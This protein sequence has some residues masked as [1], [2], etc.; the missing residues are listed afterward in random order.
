MT[1]IFVHYHLRGGGV[2]QVLKEQCRA[3]DQLGWDHGVISSQPADFCARNVVIDALDYQ[4]PHASQLNLTSCLNTVREWPL[5]RIWHIHNP[6]LG[7]HPQMASFVQDLLHHGERVILHI[8]DLAEDRRPQ[9]LARLQRHGQPW[10]LLSPRVHYLVL[11]QRDRTLLCRAGLPESQATVLINPITPDPLPHSA[12]VTPYVLYP[13]RAITRKNIGELLLLSMLAPPLSRFAT[14]QG[15]GTSYHQEEYSYWR[16]LA[17][18]EQCPIDWEVTENPQCLMDFRTLKTKATHL[19]STSTQEGFG[20]IFL[21]AIS[22]QRPLIGRSVA[23]ITDDLTSHHIHHPFLYDALHVD[24]Q[25]FG[26]ASFEEKK[27]LW[28]L[29]RAHPSKVSVVHQGHGVDARAWLAQAL[30]LDHPPLPLASIEPFHPHC[31]AKTIATIAE[32]LRKAPK[33]P[34]SYLDHPHIARGFAS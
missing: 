6:T 31:H 14:S 15:P 24:G 1:H 2:T 3:F 19:I 7:C 9:N 12:E 8:H 33:G 18:K 28:Q 21:D 34:I 17:E 13:T 29:A 16:A 27:R 25:D 20:M 23:H 22:W 10:F 4:S 5:E 32:R 26:T 11:S 30:Q